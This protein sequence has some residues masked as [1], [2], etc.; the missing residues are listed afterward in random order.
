MKKEDNNIIVNWLSKNED[1]KI[2]NQVELETQLLSD[3]YY[4]LDHYTRNGDK[5]YRDTPDWKIVELYYDLIVERIFE[6]LPETT[7]EE[8]EIIVELISNLT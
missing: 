3:F 5:H 4:W 6:R 8:D 1:S 2:A 7:D